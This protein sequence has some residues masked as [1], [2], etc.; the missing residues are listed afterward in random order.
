MRQRAWQVEVLEDPVVERAVDF[1]FQRANAVGDAL[2]VV[3][4]AMREVVHR[5]DAPLVARVMVRGVADTVEQRVAQPDVGRSHIDLRAQCSLAIGELAV[6]HAREQIQA[7]FDGAV[8]VRA[9][10]AGFIGRAAIRIRLFGR[11]VANVGLAAFDQ[12]DCPFIDLVEIV[13]G[14][15][16]FYQ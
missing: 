11:E 15:E 10:L 8:A 7:L 16:R 14:V 3:A 5:V 1:E 9:I 12:L 2:D 4:Q 13:G 6:L